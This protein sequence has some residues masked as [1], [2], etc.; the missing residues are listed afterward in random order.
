LKS[1]NLTPYTFRHLFLTRLIEAGVDI[2]L[3]AEEA[4][5]RDR[6]KTLHGTYAHVRPDYV[7]ERLKS[8]HL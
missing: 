4:G 6:G 1:P 7:R 2:R 8:V 5:H 3:A